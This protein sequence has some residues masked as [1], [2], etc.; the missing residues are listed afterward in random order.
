MSTNPFETNPFDSDDYSSDQLSPRPRS[1]KS[2][3]PQT[4]RHCRSSDDDLLPSDAEQQRY[5]YKRPEES[6]GRSTLGNDQFSRAKSDDDNEDWYAETRFADNEGERQL[7]GIKQ[8]IRNVKQDTLASTQNALQTINATQENAAH[9]LK[10][11]HEQAGKV[12]EAKC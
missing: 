2:V 12:K 11:L 4:D 5:R 3:S 1:Q 6:R 9:T 7:Q 8:D 10:N